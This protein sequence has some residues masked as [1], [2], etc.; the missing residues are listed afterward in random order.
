[1]AKNKKSQERPAF[2]SRL[3]QARKDAGLTQAEL[4]EKL[5]LSQ[6]AIANWELRETTSLRP[7]QFEALSNISLHE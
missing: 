7:D 4:G 5:G 3:A 1:M 2:G 6:R